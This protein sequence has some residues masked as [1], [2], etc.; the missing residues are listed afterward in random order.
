MIDNSANDQ[1][2]GLLKRH[3]SGRIVHHYVTWDCQPVDVYR[4]WNVWE[5]IPGCWNFGSLLQMIM[6][7]GHFLV[8]KHKNRVSSLQ[9]NWHQWMI[10]HVRIRKAALFLRPVTNIVS[11]KVHSS[12]VGRRIGESQL[13]SSEWSEL[14]TVSSTSF[15]MFSNHLNPHM[16]HFCLESH[17]EDVQEQ[18]KKSTLL[19]DSLVR[20]GSSEKHRRIQDIRMAEGSGFYVEQLVGTLW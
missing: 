1:Q 13:A 11:S 14:E 8:N 7:V 20:P 16:Q 17:A 3:T 18:L 5:N 15:G 19:V 9:Q 10:S 6:G 2:T 12:H 4:P